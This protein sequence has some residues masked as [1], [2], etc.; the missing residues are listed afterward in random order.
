MPS[1]SSPPSTS[2]QRRSVSGAAEEDMDA[3]LRRKRIE[4][5]KSEFP[6]SE[7]MSKSEFRMKGTLHRISSTLP[8]CHPEVLRRIWPFAK[9]AR[10]FG[11][12]QHDNGGQHCSEF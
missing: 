2:R 12:P 1:A 4:I 9:R 6:N 11:V 7:S 10:C 5:P 8:D 3:S